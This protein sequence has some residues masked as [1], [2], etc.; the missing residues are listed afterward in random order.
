MDEQR[1]GII[2]SIEGNTPIQEEEMTMTTETN[3]VEG[4]T[5]E[6][7]YPLFITLPTSN[8]THALDRY[9][10]E[11]LELPTKVVGNTV[12][13]T[14]DEDQVDAIE[15]RLEWMERSMG[16]AKNF[17]SVSHVVRDGAEALAKIAPVAVGAAFKAMTTTAGIIG[18]TTVQSGAAGV[19]SAHSDFK[20]AAAE[21][22]ADQNVQDAKQILVGLFNKKRTKSRFINV[23]KG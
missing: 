8:A 23:N 20:R 2:D 1:P 11:R 12:Y 6:K 14:A 17:A 4:T 21:L 13:V 15:T 9:I 5:G 10:Q 18:K 19:K 7:L 3:T 16:L 22:H